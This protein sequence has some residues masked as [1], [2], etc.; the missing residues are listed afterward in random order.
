MQDVTKAQRIE[1]LLDLFAQQQESP[2]AAPD[3]AELRVR[4]SRILEAGIASQPM[5]QSIRATVLLSDLRGF[6]SVAEKYPPLE[7]MA[8]L[9]R[10]L[11]RMSEI[12]IRRGGTVDKFMGDGI[13]AVFGP[14]GLRDDG[15]GAALACAIEMQ[16]AM[17]AINDANKSFGMPPLYMGIGINTGEMVAGW[18]GSDLHRE[19]TVIGDQVNLASRVEA[20][21]LRGQ[22]LLSESTYALARD[23]IE[24]GDINEVRIKGRQC[25]I[26]MYELLATSKPAAL[27]VPRR[28][29]R[30]GPRVLADM[31]LTFHL[32]RG[33]S[34]LPTEHRAR[35]TD[36][37][38]GGMCIVTDIDIPL[39]AEVR[40]GL[41]LAMLAGETAEIYAR[42]LAASSGAD[43]HE[44]RLE[45]TVIDPPCAR[46]IK[47][48]VDSLLELRRGL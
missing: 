46:A 35:V 24:T 19:Y 28:E 29:V 17:D 25:V 15:V 34:V 33:K 13:L 21:S 42:V 12:I 6:M 22:I 26:R 41:T 20:H 37:S 14:P 9:N 45:F 11:G 1:Q 7:M 3:L 8:A 48:L 10:Y 44:Y 18:Q 23:F 4:I 39:L 43:G 16:I 27:S 36:I 5:A 47:E 32:M 38:Y 31:P 30:N 2:A 40:I